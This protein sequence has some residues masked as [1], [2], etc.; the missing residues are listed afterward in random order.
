MRADDGRVVSNV[1]C[2]ALAGDDITIYGDGS[3]TRSFCYVS[4]L[5][6]GFLRLMAYEGEPPGAVNLGNPN[7]LSV[8]DLARCVLKLTGSR[9]AIVHRPLPLDDPRRR[10]PDITRAGKLLGWVPKTSLETGLKATF[11][12]FA[13]ELSRESEPVRAPA[14][15]NRAVTA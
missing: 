15:L 2:Q 6:E 10:C 4:D 7:E 12:W 3:Q 13:E 1:I 14:G 9:S 11:P 8:T 5:I